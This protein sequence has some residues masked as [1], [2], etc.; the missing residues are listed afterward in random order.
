MYDHS[1]QYQFK[2]VVKSIPLFLPLY[3]VKLFVD[4]KFVSQII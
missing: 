3:V 4:S 2:T 1:I